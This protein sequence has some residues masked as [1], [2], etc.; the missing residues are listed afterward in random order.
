MRIHLAGAAILVLVFGG[1]LS[2]SQQSPDSQ[3]PAAP[4]S[5]AD[6]EHGLKA[7]VSNT[8]MAALVK[9]YGVDFD[10]TDAIEKQLRAAGANDELLLRI[11]RTARPS[12]SRS[13]VISPP[14]ASPR[15]MPPQSQILQIAS[16]V[17]LSVVAIYLTSTKQHDTASGVIVDPKGYIMT[18]QHVVEK[19]DQIRVRLQD[20]ATGVLHDA[21]LIGMDQETDLAVIKIDVDRQLPIAKLGN[22]DN[23]QVGDRVLAVGSPFGLPQTVTAGIISAKGHNIVPNRKFQS[24]IQ[25]DMAINPIDSGGPLVNMAGEVIGI[26][27]VI[28]TDTNA[29]AGVGFAMP[30]N[31]IAQV[32]NQ[33]IGPEHRVVRSSIG[34][35]SGAYDS[36]MSA[37]PI[38]SPASAPGETQASLA[39]PAASNPEGKVLAAKV[40][41]AMGGLDRLQSV[42]SWR[43]KGTIS[44]PEQ[45]TWVFEDTV[46]YPD[47]RYESE[48]TL[49]PR[50]TVVTP[51]SY[52]TSWGGVLRDGTSEEKRE[53]L[54]NL[55]REDLHLIRRVND[56]AITFAA[57]A[58]E[59]VGDVQAAV[60]DVGGG[61]PAIRW[62]V[63]PESGRL[64]RE[65]GLWGPDQIEVDHSDWRTA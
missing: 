41:Q 62:F 18:N 50:V 30:S 40:A 65:L 34:V 20:D 58:S 28:L 39:K 29:R 7:G 33:L 60:V 51:E 22:S 42:K 26:N 9:Q 1:H 64:L 61:V 13:P 43:Y 19:V 3:S 5:V 46:V 31:T 47:R 63:D 52:F 8:R 21:R 32:Y 14:G 12:S 11:A 59:K 35:E 54:A 15:T 4:L 16:K 55:H 17:K 53:H 44:D 57:V 24:F 6:V 48:G 2:L 27:T 38:P 10:L 56:P 37:S 36:S 23:M 25:T 49:R 45:G